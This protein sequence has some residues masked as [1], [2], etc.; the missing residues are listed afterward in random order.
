MPDEAARQEDLQRYEVL[1]TPPDEALDD[2]TGLAAQ[3]CGTPIALISLIDG[4]R[5]W[6]K[7]KVGIEQAELPRDIS[8]CGHA[9]HQ[10]ELLIVPDAAQDVRFADNPL[11]TGEPHIRFYAGAPLISPGD[12]ALGTLC[13]IDR[14]PRTLTPNQEKALRV[15]ARQVMMY[16][17]LRRQ[18]RELAESEQRLRVI[19]KQELY[20]EK[21]ASHRLSAIVESSDDAI[22]GKDLDS[23]VTSWNKGAERIFGYTA[24]EMVGTSILRLIPADRQEEEA[25]ILG[26]IRRGESV[27]HFETVRQTKDGRLIDMSVAI[28][29]IKDLTGRVVGASK[30]A[31]DITERRKAEQQ[32]RLLDTCI[33]KLNDI[34]VVTEADPIDDPGPRIV[35]V[36]D[37]FE[38]ICGYSRAEAIGRSPRFLQGEKTDRRVLA[39]IR[40]ALARRQPIRRE[41]INYA[42]DGSEYWL[43]MD[44]VPI[45][46]PA[47]HCTHF[48]A[49]ERDITEAKK[50]EARYRTL[51]EHAPDGI[52]IADARS[53]YLE[54]NASICRMLGYTRDELIGKHASDIVIPSEISQIGPAIDA[55]QTK[56]EYHREW[57][58]RRKDGSFFSAEVIATMLPDGNLLGMIRDITERKR[59]EERI[60]EQAALLDKAQDAIVALDLERNVLFWNHGAERLYG[61]KREEV[62]G[63]N[64]T[65]LFYANYEKFEEINLRTMEKGEWSGELVHLTK[66]RREI[67]VQ[68]RRTLIL[69]QAGQPKSVLVI[70]TDITEKKKIEAQFMR[71]QRMESIG[72]LAGGVAHDLNN[73]LAPI[74]MSIDVLKTISENSQAKTI[75]E[76][77]EV[78]ARRGADIV[79]QVLSFAR[80][81]EGERVEVQP[82]HLFKDLENIIKDTFPKDIQMRFSIPNDIWTMVGDPTQIH[83]VLLNLCVNARDAMPHGGNLTIAVENCLLDEHFAAMNVEAK[84][85]RYVYISVSDTGTGIPPSLIDK[86]FEPFFT[87]K[88]MSK[89]TGLGLSTV[90]AIV[91]SHGGTINVYSESGRGT[92]FKVYLPAM[93]T[94]DAARKD[95]AEEASLPRGHGETV[96]VI[97]DEA[98]ILVVTSQ[99]L[100]AFGYHVLTAADGAAAVA[101][102]AA[103]MN[104]IA[105][106]L[107]DMAMPV[108]DGPATIHALVRIN[109]NVKIVAASGLETNGGAAK[110]SGYG[111]K[112]FLNKPYTAGTLLKTLRAILSEA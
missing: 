36:N 90:M 34:V 27:E 66:D 58:F 62:L 46:D 93:E 6:F 15:L 112:H 83:Q 69:D 20:A 24:A 54:A 91:K 95:V 8:F 82:R 60:A 29:P 44:I 28:S 75:L 81:L 37:A 26:K 80:G 25:L 31:R 33:A 72:T 51:F 94:S 43:D 101:V 73:I 108:M 12:V 78:S 99:T 89:G 30:V 64:I 109:P 59:S 68:S 97:D 79:R 63:R 107:T 42:K 14:V 53:Y 4:N 5:Q 92:T 41:V 74:M 11:V 17:D 9:L 84:P 102:Y 23:I 2:L 104:E 86:I 88:E 21:T 1:D 111:V 106:V 65:E 70:N 7:S 76:T 49:I 77:I 98:S 103:H 40:E 22:V 56:P 16:L 87:T 96:L 52:V 3:I 39:E 110:V 48:A 18:A 32:L 100:Q 85:G 50:T 10:R 35:F 19:T 67:V 13:M 71:A 105:V 47:G 45:L 61:W 38:R 55:I 57:Q